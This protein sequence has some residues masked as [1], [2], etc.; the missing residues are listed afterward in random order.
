MP[1]VAS[2]PR[3]QAGAQKRRLAGAGRAE[4]HQQPRRRRL[5][6]AAQ[7]VERF[8]DRRV[9]AEEDA[10]VL[11]FERAQPAIRRTVRVAVGRPGEEARIEA[12]L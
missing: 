2:Q 9:A 5:A 8:E 11:G 4:D 10:G 3:Q 1:V 7:P 12:R 6:Q